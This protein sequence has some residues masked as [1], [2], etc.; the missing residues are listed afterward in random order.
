MRKNNYFKI[1]TT[2]KFLFY[3]IIYILCILLLAGC[4]GHNNPITPPS[5]GGSDGTGGNGGTPA[6][7]GKIVFTSDR[8]N[9]EKGEIYIMNADGTNV[10]RL[11]NNSYGDAYADITPEGNTIAF[12]SDRYFNGQGIE[13]CL[14][15]S[16][17]QNQRRVTNNSVDELQFSISPDGKKIVYSIKD[18][19]ANPGKDIYIINADGTGETKLTNNPDMDGIPNNPRYIYFN[20]TFSP[21]GTKIA[22][23]AIDLLPDSELLEIYIMNSDGSN[24]QKILSVTG[25][26]GIYPDINM[27]PSLSPDGSKLVFSKPVQKIDPIFGVETSSFEIFTMNIDGSNLQ[28]VTT[29]AYATVL[30]NFN[31]VFS[32]DG[33]K[34][35][36]HSMRDGDYEIY[37]VNIDGSNTINITNNSDLDMDPAFSR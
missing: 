32:P 11:T 34:I 30:A 35:A 33:T 15:D 5:N 24:P 3:P 17:G 36:Y 26:G 1:P 16:N 19:N 10:R 37:L 22:Y 2:R 12:L 7:S 8:D 21:D 27:G 28:Q 25:N 31:P 20:P 18:V 23:G 9:K 6:I 13:I 14:M 4:G 29:D